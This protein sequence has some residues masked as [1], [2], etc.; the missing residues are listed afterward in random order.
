M[1]IRQQNPFGNTLHVGMVGRFDESIFF[2]KAGLIEVAHDNNDGL[3]IAEVELEDEDEAVDLP[4]WA[5]R[6]VS[7]LMRYYNASLSGHP[8]RDWSEGEKA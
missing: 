5:G 7:G 6:E 8:Y 1:G 4:P 3:V 2:S